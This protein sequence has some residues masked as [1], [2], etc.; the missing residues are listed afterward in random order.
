MAQLQ[1]PSNAQA[2][3]SLRYALFGYDLGHRGI[4][5]KTRLFGKAGLAGGVQGD[6]TQLLISMHDAD[7]SWLVYQVHVGRTDQIHSEDGWSN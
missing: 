4:P 7:R 6:Y 5:P 3:R 2:N 1:Q